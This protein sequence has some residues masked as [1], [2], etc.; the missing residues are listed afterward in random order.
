MLKQ[1]NDE[2]N[3]TRAP[4]LSLIIPFLIQQ[5]PR[6]TDAAHSCIDVHDIDD[7]NEIQTQRRIQT[8]E[9]CAMHEMEKTPDASH[10]YVA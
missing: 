3:A 10:D 4:F 8:F 7:V 9:V 6:K 1:G 5:K 2:H